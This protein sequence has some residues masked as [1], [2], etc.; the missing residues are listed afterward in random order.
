MGVPRFQAA[1]GTDI[2]GLLELTLYGLKGAAA[3]ADHALVLGYEDASLYAQFHEA[4]DFL[5]DPATG[6]PGRPTSTPFSAGS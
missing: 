1:L 6:C 4:L 3:Y 5:A 2:A